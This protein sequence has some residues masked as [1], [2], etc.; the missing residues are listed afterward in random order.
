[1]PDCFEVPQRKSLYVFLTNPKR[2][3]YN[4]NVYFRYILNSISGRIRLLDNA[5]VRLGL[6][7]KER[8]E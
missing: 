8:T 2:S 3:D 6:F 7:T 4:F 1:M 5:P